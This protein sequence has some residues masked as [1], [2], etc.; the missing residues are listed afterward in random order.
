LLSLY[1]DNLTIDASS[2]GVILD[3]SRAPDGTNGLIVSADGCAVYGLTIQ[4]FS[5]NG[6]ILELGASGNRIGGDRNL[7]SGPN[8]RGNRIANNGGSGVD[9]RGPGTAGNLLQGNFI[10]VDAAA[11]EAGLITVR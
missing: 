11:F 3:G 7:G 5:S 6:V 4:N 10:G 2:A 8:G 1:Q 9:L